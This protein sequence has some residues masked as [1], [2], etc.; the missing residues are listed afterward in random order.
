MNT[1][2]TKSVISIIIVLTFCFVG[3]TLALYPILSG[4]PIAEYMENIRIFFAMYSGIVGVIVG[5]YF[6]SNNKNDQQK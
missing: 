3:A 1:E 4:T 5:Y 2:K 6:G